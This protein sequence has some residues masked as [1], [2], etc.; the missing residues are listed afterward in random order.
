[1]RWS[2]A[3]VCVAGA[4]LARAHVPEEMLSSYV[5]VMKNMVQHE[6]GTIKDTNYAMDQAAKALN[7][8]HANPV[9]KKQ[10]SALLSKAKEVEQK[11]LAL[12]E[13]SLKKARLGLVSVPGKNTVDLAADSTAQRTQNA[14]R[15]DELDARLLN[16]A[17]TF[18]SR[19]AD[20]PVKA[21]VDKL[22]SGVL[23]TERRS[24]PGGLQRK[25]RGETKHVSK[26]AG[27]GSDEADEALDVNKLEH[28]NAQLRKTHVQLKAELEILRKEE[29]LV[30]EEKKLENENRELSTQIMALRQE[31]AVAN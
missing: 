31:G 13:T 21:E 12:E 2:Q 4:C 27:E 18:R 5:R 7:A 8:E 6:V 26:H 22:L 29:S 23:E 24:V 20:S 15:L 28:R 10:V 1:M 11:T 25:L 30:E 14:S 3:V 17:M 9:V 19:V 16:E